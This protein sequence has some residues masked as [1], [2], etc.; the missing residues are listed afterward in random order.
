M[1]VSCFYRMDVFNNY[2]CQEC[3]RGGGGGGG[4]PVTKKKKEKDI[5]LPQKQEYIQTLNKKQ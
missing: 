4:G 3:V 2:H 1:N 5:T